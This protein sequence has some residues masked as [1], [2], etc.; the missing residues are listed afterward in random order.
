MPKH[1]SFD[2]YFKETSFDTLR[3]HPVYFPD[4]IS[5]L[6]KT[7]IPYSVLLNEKIPLDSGAYSPISMFY[8]NKNKSLL[9]YLV[10]EIIPGDVNQIIYLLV[11]SAANNSYI[12]NREIAS[13]AYMESAFE[14]TMNSWLADLN[15]D[16]Y[17][18]IATKKHLIDFE[19]PTEE[20]ENISG[21]ESFIYVYK[22]GAFEFV[23]WDEGILPRAFVLK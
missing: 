14:Q 10:R 15:N 8:M 20:S 1:I 21:G 13:Y 12:F 23:Y 9:G 22:N 4:S 2:S 17:L 11:Y 7:V 3:V 16:G 5:S 18:D 19:M 6:N